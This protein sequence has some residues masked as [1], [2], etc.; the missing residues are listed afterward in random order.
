MLHKC[1]SHFRHPFQNKAGGTNQ[2]ALD[3]VSHYTIKDEP[4][5]LL[6]KV[7][8]RYY[9]ASHKLICETAAGDDSLRCEDYDPRNSHGGDYSWPPVESEKITE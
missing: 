9:H 2:S 1:R 8:D 7:D 5:Q 4:V 3:V 6:L